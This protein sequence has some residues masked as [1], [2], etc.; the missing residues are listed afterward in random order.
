MR[1][2]LSLCFQSNR[3]RIESQGFEISFFKEKGIF[4]VEKILLGIT[5]ANG[6]EK[7]MM[8]IMCD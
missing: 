6:Q 4:S 8:S 2:S 3:A 5:K 7:I 1:F